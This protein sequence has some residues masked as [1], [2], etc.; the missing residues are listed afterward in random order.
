MFGSLFSII[1][2][3]SYLISSLLLNTLLFLY[4]PFSDG[5]YMLLVLMFPEIVWESYPLFIRDFGDAFDEETL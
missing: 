5:F 3:Y 4:R 2:S 1:L